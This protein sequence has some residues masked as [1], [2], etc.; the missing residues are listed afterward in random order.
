[1][2]TGESM[3]EMTTEPQ[4]QA[5][6]KFEKKVL[7]AQLTK[8]IIISPDSKHLEFKVN[9]L[10]QFPFVA[11]QFVSIRQP[12]PDGKLHT[13]AY[14]IASPP[15]TDGTFDVVLNRVD[16]GFMSNWLCDI[17]VG[18]NVT[19]HGPHGLFTMRQPKHD[20]VFI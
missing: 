1:M 18:T 2:T 16:E 20:A 14:S 15:R 7:T 5:P 6:A 12:R 9:E 11:G 8:S 3:S 13:R 4:P 17:E 19:F 10:E